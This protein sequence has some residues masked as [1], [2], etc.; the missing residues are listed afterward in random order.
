MIPILITVL[1]CV[2]VLVVSSLR[3]SRWYLSRYLP[4]PPPPTE[5][6]RLQR[7]LADHEKARLGAIQRGL[8]ATT[9]NHSNAI[10]D[11]RKRIDA[12]E[13]NDDFEEPKERLEP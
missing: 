8:P 5:R 13:D 7:V 3:F 6:Q 10:R 2:T 4:P 11:I 12:L 1:A 9:D